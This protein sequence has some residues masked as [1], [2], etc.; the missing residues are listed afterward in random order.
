MKV[1]FI[2]RKMIKWVIVAM[3]VIV[4]IIVLILVGRNEVPTIAQTFTM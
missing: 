2:K 3:A 4:L 1:F